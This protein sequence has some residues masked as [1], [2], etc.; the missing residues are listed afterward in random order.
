MA[1][2]RARFCTTCS[3]SIDDLLMVLSGMGGYSNIGLIILVYILNFVLVVHRLNLCTLASAFFALCSLLSTCD[4]I[5]QRV[6][7]SPRN[8]PLFL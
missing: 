5:P 8:L 4:L 3:F 1:H 6:N 2:L 7:C